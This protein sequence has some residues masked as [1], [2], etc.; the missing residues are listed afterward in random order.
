M[1]K[2]TWHPKKEEREI[3]FLYHKFFNRGDRL[4]K[5]N[6]M[7]GI[8][9]MA[10]K[11]ESFIYDVVDR[12]SCRQDLLDELK[13]L[14]KIVN[15]S[16][17]RDPELVKIMMQDVF[18]EHCLSAER[19]DWIAQTNGRLCNFIWS[20]LLSSTRNMRGL[21]CNQSLVFDD[22]DEN[23]SRQEPIV[24]IFRRDENEYLELNLPVHV[25]TSHDKKRYIVR[26]FDL[27]DVPLHSKENQMAN[28]EDIWGQIKNKSK[29]EDWLV[30][31]E[32]MA[33]WA[34]NYTFKTYLGFKNPIWLDLSGVNKNENAKQAMI[35][36]YDLLS[37]AHRKILMS[38]LSKSGSQQKYRTNS[39]SEARTA[40]SIQLSDERKNML[41]KMASDSNRK[42]YQV[43]E[44]MIDQEYQK[45]YSR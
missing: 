41:R 28:F 9:D 3:V 31:N 44:D 21:Q 43:V 6:A 32:G 29:M 24:D 36:L 25:N 2:M 14:N 20:F 33:E 19:F 40:M 11:L 18:R 22:E 12:E 13:K 35:T 4:R 45:R 26:F 38:S 30:N 23:N 37:V 39:A 17:C 34:W 27:W 10:S 5:G 16:E 7:P 15:Y 8:E 42:I 1:T